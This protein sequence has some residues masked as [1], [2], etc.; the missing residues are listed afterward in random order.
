MVV[1][2]WVYFILLLFSPG[3]VGVLENVGGKIIKMRG[4]VP[5]MGVYKCMSPRKP[6]GDFLYTLMGVDYNL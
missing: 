2:V 5:A 3:W 6:T 1:W 4:K